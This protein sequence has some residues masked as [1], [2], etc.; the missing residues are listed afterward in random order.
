MSITQSIVNVVISKESARLVTAGFGIPN[1]LAV[2]NQPERVFRITSPAEASQKYGANSAIV[3]QANTVFGQTFSPAYMVVS[4]MDN[5]ATYSATAQTATVTIGAGVAEGDIFTVRVNRTVFS[6]TALSGDVQAD[7]ATALEALIGASPSLAGKVSSSVLGAVI[8]IVADGDNAFNL[9]ANTTGV[10]TTVVAVANNYSQTTTVSV[11]A[12]VNEG[13]TYSV[14]IN[15]VGITYTTTDTDT[16][17]SVVSSLALAIAN[18]TALTGEVVVTASGNVLTLRGYTKDKAFG[19]NASVKESVVGGETI[20]SALVGGTIVYSA[21]N[22][23][24]ESLSEDGSW[25]G[26][27]NQNIGTSAEMKAD[28]IA[29]ATAVEGLGGTFPRLYGTLTN[30]ASSADNTFDV[31]GTDLGNVLSSSGFA[32]TYWFWTRNIQDKVESAAMGKMFGTEPGAS[33]WFLQSFSGIR[34]D[35]LNGSQKGNIKLKSGNFYEAIDAFNSGVTS[36]AVCADGTYIDVRTSIDLLTA[37]LSEAVF[38]R[39]YAAS[40]AGS[41]I[42]FTQAGIES[43][44]NTV[45]T[46]L[47]RQPD[48]IDIDTIV[49]NAPN[50]AEV[51]PADKAARWLNKVTFTATLTGAFHGVTI[52]GTLVD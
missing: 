34:G 47:Q 9:F 15:K 38:G 31:D 44:V 50:I 24:N 7:V 25:Y 18:N 43:I 46:T 32:R 19:V 8:T 5:T 42:P 26:V 23:M 21:V 22:A 49:V 14:W 37:R 11:G 1:F 52:Q 30:E 51:D 20:V 29:L 16:Q 48:I 45:K 2:H 17:A 3:A 39:L 41:K 40:N 12:T 6:Y 13:A 28:S 27:L 10:A 4:K 35:K 36:D 33:T